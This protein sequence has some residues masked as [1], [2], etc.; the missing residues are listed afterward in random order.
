MQSYTAKIEQDDIDL[1]RQ[2]YINHYDRKRYGRGKKGNIP[3][4][5][6]SE[7]TSSKPLIRGFAG[8]SI[9][10]S[11]Y[12]VMIEDGMLELA[13]AV[14][15]AYKKRQQQVLQGNL[16]FKDLNNQPLS[17]SE[18]SL[19][20]SSGWR[21]PERNEWYSNAIN[22]IHQ[23]GAALDII[24]NERPGTK[25]TAATYWLLWQALSANKSSIPGYWQLETHGRPMKTSEYKKDISPKNGIPDAF[26]L[27]DH[28]HIQ[29]E[30]IK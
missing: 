12:P 19:W 26:D 17:V 4:P 6:R 23:R 16:D 21:N 18:K 9:T 11:I 3:V 27:A 20:L 30:N 14:A 1:L 7:V 5:L 24:P 15:K 29:M 25:K 2:E 10:S 28:L 22:G 8:G 13:N